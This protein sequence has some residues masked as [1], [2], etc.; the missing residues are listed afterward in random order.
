MISQK[1]FAWWSR[2][3][4]RNPR[5]RRVWLTLVQVTQTILKPREREVGVGHMGKQHNILLVVK[6]GWAYGVGGGRWKYGTILNNVNAQPTTHNAS[7][8]RNKWS[9]TRA[10]PPLPYEC[11]PKTNNIFTGTHGNKC[12]N[13]STTTVLINVWM[14]PRNNWPY[15][16]T[17]FNL[18][19]LAYYIPSWNLD[20][21]TLESLL[22]GRDGLNG[23]T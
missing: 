5:E 7:P 16:P 18:V 4:R 15:K 11:D 9:D 22:N 8:N 10:P 6:W 20:S 14:W 21:S 1:V 13:A 19:A 2:Q 12:L 3:P 17:I 23:W